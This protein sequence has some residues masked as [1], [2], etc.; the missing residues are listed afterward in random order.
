MR[1]RMPIR[2]VRLCPSFPQRDLSRRPPRGHVAGAPLAYT[3]AG[4][5]GRVSS[6]GSG[7]GLIT[8]VV[9]GW[10]VCVC[11]GALL[12]SVLFAP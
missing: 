10:R 5:C 11:V 3:S 2:I 8:R 9:F 7:S 12:Y 6:W 4:G 1:M